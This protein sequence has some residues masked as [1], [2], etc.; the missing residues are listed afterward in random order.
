MNTQTLRAIIVSLTLALSIISSVVSAAP[1]RLEFTEPLGTTI[2]D[3]SSWVVVRARITNLTD[4]SFSL[5]VG[6]SGHPSDEF[7]Y[8]ADVY[9]WDGYLQFTPTLSPG[10][11]IDLE[12]G[13]LAPRAVAP[14]G[15]YEYD[16]HITFTG[17]ETVHSENTFFWTVGLPIS[18]PA[19]LAL[20]A[21]GLAGLGVVRQRS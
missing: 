15:F 19:T 9:S 6:S 21:L 1:L 2:E 14:R 17:Y 4:N 7:L 10:E 20:L 11:T 18:E 12:F 3:G 16:L 8:V 13:R 5:N